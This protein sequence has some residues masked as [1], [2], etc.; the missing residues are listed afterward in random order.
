[1]ATLWQLL[2]I[3][4]LKTLIYKGLMQKYT[5]LLSSRSGVR[6]PSGVPKKKRHTEYGV[7]DFAKTTAEE[8]PVGSDSL[9]AYQI[10]NVICFSYNVFY[11]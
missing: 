7:F 11:F 5:C 4:C 3:I 1:M 6:L 9:P 10:K 8:N 2:K